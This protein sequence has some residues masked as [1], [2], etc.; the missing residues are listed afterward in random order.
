MTGDRSNGYALITGGALG[1]GP[2]IARR[3]ARDGWQIGISC[4][5]ELAQANAVA[6]CIRDAGGVAVVLS[7]DLGDPR[8]VTDMFRRVT[9]EYAPV[10]VLVNTADARS[11]RSLAELDEE[12]WQ[13]V[14]DTN[15]RAAVNTTRC[16][17]RPMIRARF[18]R[19]INIA[20]AP[21]LMAAPRT[22]AY[23]TSKGALIAF[24]KTLAAE[25]S[26]RG[27][28]VNAVAPG[29]IDGR[30]TGPE[31]DAWEKHVPARRLG[32]PDEVAGC[33]GFL[34]SDE[35]SYVSGSVL[36]V[37]GGLTA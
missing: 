13:R 24:T 29:L 15:L 9:S 6:E 37:D 20:A 14:L 16:A 12:E 25:V 19:I 31:R 3:L 32:S 8:A 22:A 27:V 11:E 18:G 17:L 21:G 5:P 35:A 28:T 23:A 30:A 33:V 7:C 10:N 34:A 2:A 36:M 1:I 26:Y 4:G